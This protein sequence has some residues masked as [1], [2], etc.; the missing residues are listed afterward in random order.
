MKKIIHD[1][2]ECLPKPDSNDVILVGIDDC[3][4]SGKSTIAEALASE[5]SDSQLVHV[6][7]FYKPKNQRVEIT[8]NTPVHANFEFERLKQQVLSPIKQGNSATFITTA[9]RE[10]EINPYGYVI[11]EGLGTLG[12]ELRNYFDFKI[13]VDA[14]EFVRRDR[15]I[16]R[17]SKEWTDIWDNEY[18][19][20]DAR[21][22][23]EQSP[24]DVADKILS[25]N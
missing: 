24:E 23:L 14:V 8:K 7:D 5:L 20:Q 12:H 21:Y 11:V 15:G 17:D 3:G 9:G 4:G 22:M 16:S 10:V 25:N 6:D 13:W 1:L 2:I 19:P 18:L